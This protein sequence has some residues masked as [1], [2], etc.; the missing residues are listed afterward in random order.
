M[1]SCNGAVLSDLGTLHFFQQNHDQ[2]VSRYEESLKINPKHEG[3]LYNLASI[4]YMN[5]DTEKAKS[6]L[7][8]CIGIQ[9]GHL[10]A[11]SLHGFDV[12]GR[13]DV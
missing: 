1:D 5:G 7:Q 3:T 10:H 8:Q 11:I 2:A 9:P 12:T 6:M 13:E 4:H